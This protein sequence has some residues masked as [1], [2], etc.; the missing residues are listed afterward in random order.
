MARPYRAL[1]SCLLVAGTAGVPGTP[2]ACGGQLEYLASPELQGRES[3]QPGCV[4]AATYLAGKMQAL[5]LSTLPATGMGGETPCHHTY[6]L[7]SYLSGGFTLNGTTL[8]RGLHYT[9]SVLRSG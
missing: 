6:T 7:S 4:K 5:G 8:L 3:G 1:I 9:S 2:P